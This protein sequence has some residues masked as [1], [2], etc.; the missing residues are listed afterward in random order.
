MVRVKI[1]C[2]EVSKIPK[3][4]LYEMKENIYVVQFKVEGAGGQKESEG[5]DD[6]GGGGVMTLEMLMIRRCRS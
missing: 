3:K 6:W 5:G 4:R 2:K 1:A